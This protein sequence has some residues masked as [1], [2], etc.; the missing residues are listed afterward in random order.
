MVLVAA[1]GVTVV[2]IVG[3]AVGVTMGGT[4]GT[5]VAIIEG[6]I[7]GVIWW[8]KQSGEEEDYKIHMT[9]FCLYSRFAYSLAYFKPKSDISP[10]LKKSDICVSTLCQSDV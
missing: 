9:E 3:V 8:K 5:I 10:T 1:V 2:V 7:V 6:A 4:A